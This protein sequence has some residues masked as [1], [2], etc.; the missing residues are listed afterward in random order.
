VA[1]GTDM[2]VAGIDDAGYMPVHGKC[3]VEQNVKKLDCPRTGA[4]CQPSLTL[5]AVSALL[6]LDV[7]HNEHYTENR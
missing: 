4:W 2:K 5:P 6:S 1:Q 3:L 7:Q